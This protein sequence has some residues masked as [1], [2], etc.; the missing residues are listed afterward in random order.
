MIP[1]F[2]E[3]ASVAQPDRA[4][5]F[6]P[7]GRGFEPLR[8]HQKHT[9]SRGVFF[10]ALNEGLH[11]MYSLTFW[12][13]IVRVSDCGICFRRGG[14]MKIKGVSDFRSLLSSASPWVVGVCSMTTIVFAA[15]SRDV[16]E[17]GD[18][19]LPICL[20]EMD[21]VDDT[22]ASIPSPNTA[23]VP[24]I[25]SDMN[26]QPGPCEGFPGTIQVVANVCDD[27]RGSF[28]VRL[29]PNDTPNNRI[30]HLMERVRSYKLDFLNRH[31]LSVTPITDTLCINGVCAAIM[32]GAYGRYEI[33]K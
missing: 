4:R 25:L 2:E 23:F 11:R 16:S 30:A 20:E 24:A 3:Y 19:I 15:C 18:Q 12:Q 27:G 21:L 31:I 26:I 29:N 32:Y 9:T 5:G 28:F 8:S 7:R 17:R 1:E 22:I 6:E 14:V 13:K 10:C 33:M